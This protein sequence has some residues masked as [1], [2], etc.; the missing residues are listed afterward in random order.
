MSWFLISTI[1][2]GERLPRVIF[3]VCSITLSSWLTQ[4]ARLSSIQDRVEFR[5][6]STFSLLEL[7]SA[8]ASSLIL[9]WYISLVSASFSASSL[10]D[11]L[12]LSAEICVNSS[13]CRE[14]WSTVSIRLW[15][16]SS[17]FSAFCSISLREARSAVCSS[18]LATPLVS[19][20]NSSSMAFSSS[21]FRFISSSLLFIVSSSIF[22]ASSLLLIISSLLFIVSSSIFTASSLLFII[23]SLLFIVS[24]SSFTASALL[25]NISSL[26]F[27]VSS[28]VWISCSLW[29]LA[30]SSST[31]SSLSFCSSVDISSS[32]LRFISSSVTR[33]ISIFSNC[34]LSSSVLFVSWL[35]IRS[36][37]C[38]SNSH[39]WACA[40][41]SLSALAF[42]ASLLVLSSCPIS[43]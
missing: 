5:V 4:L 40:A 18:T 23:S 28:F 24:S 34:R 32:S 26:I 42:T 12:C 30:V 14:S 6:F 15:L 35:V 41:L 1:S 13:F 11:L 25:F 3:I 39:T 31:F 33:S 16:L 27:I 43:P 38:F 17:Y 22:T 2:E 9:S 36:V 7:P 37:S 21:T 20:A 19:A 8:D 29:V 10:T